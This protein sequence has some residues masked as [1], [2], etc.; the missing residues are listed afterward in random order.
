MI[1]FFIKKAF[2]DGWDNLVQIMVC[3]VILML[4]GFSGLYLASALLPALLPAL[5]VFLLTCALLGALLS[6]ASVLFS[7][8]ARYDSFAFADIVPALR[9]HGPHGAL[10]GLLI[11]ALVCVFAVA[12]PYY[13]SISSLFG[14]VSAA[15][16]F[17][18]AI[19]LLLSLQWFFPIRSQLDRGF[20]KSLKKCFIIFLDNP[21]FSFFFFLYSLVLLG[22]S[23]VLV[24]LLPGFAG[25]QLAANEALRLRLYKYDWLEKHP[26]LDP[27]KARRAIPW[28][29]LLAEDFETTGNR[30]LKSFL[31]PW[32]D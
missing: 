17:W 7:R 29:E 15:M 14:F 9:S 6:A 4:F 11:A 5:A 1:G 28:D 3:N 8:V 26:E 18:F 24:F 12:F 2:Y 22:L 30:T 13:L 21:G 19:A 10:F 20:L 25:I 27:V 31:F 16:L 32:K 23:L